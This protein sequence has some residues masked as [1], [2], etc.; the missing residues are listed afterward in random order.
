MNRPSNREWGSALIDRLAQLGAETFCFS[1]GARSSALV[2]ALRRVRGIGHYDE[3]GMAFFALGAARVSGKPSVIITTS[4]SAVANLLPAVVEASH[5]HVPMILLTADRPAELRGR[6]SNQT[7]TQPGI[8]SDNI[9]WETEL[10]CPGDQ[11][12]FSAALER[13]D[14][15]WG[16]AMG[17]PPGPVHLNVPFR[18]PL[19][20]Q[21]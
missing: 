6:G 3:R 7:I 2:A 11:A 19:L 9:R 10:P 18:E 14:E 15:A 16:H 20:E 17:I 12:D 4:G 8:F 5:A 1:P 13:C 21:E